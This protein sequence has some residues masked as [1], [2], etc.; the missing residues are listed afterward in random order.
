VRRKF[1]KPVGKPLRPHVAHFGATPRFLPPLPFY[2]GGAPDQP[3]KISKL[4]QDRMDAY[5][6]HDKITQQ[7]L[8]DCMHVSR[9]SVNQILNDRRAITADMALRLE[10]VFG[11]EPRCPLLA[12]STVGA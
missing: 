7:E 1:N 4:L 3:P 2:E 9:H 5:Q 10:R 8:A 6:P 11:G 12:P